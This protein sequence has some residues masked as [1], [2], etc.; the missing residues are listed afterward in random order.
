M[1]D[2]ILTVTFGLVYGFGGVEKK[3]VLFFGGGIGELIGVF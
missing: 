3:S 1:N 2:L